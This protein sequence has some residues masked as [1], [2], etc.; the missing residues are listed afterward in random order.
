MSSLNDL[1]KQIEFWSLDKESK[2]QPATEFLKKYMIR[3]TK[4]QRI[5]GEVALCLPESTKTVKMVTM[6]D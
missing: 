3:H 1:N 6:S 4:S 2:A 5:N